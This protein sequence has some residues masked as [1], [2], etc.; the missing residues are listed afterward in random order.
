M[1]TLVKYQKI[2]V[3]FLEEYAQISYANAPN[4]E[5]QVIADITR[6]HFEL[7]SIGWHKGQFVHDVVF[8]FDIKDNKVWIQQNWTDL[9]LTKILIQKGIDPAD[10]VIGF[11]QPQLV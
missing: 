7:V 11:V 9:K 4:L 10:I 1:E 5:Q 2:L 3:S 8:H 6:N